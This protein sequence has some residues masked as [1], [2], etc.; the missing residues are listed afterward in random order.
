LHIWGVAKNVKNASKMQKW[1]EKVA[2]GQKFL[3]EKLASKLTK[4][5]KKWR[6]L[7]VFGRFLAFFDC[8]LSFVARWPLFFYLFYKKNFFIF[9]IYKRKTGFLANL[10]KNG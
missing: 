6:F 1:P 8:F 9:K 3:S 10:I 4:I 2:S 7:V 5:V